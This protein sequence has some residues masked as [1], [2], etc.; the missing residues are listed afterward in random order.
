MKV[1]NLFLLYQLHGGAHWPGSL[2]K[3]LVDGLG[4]RDMVGQATLRLYTQQKDVQ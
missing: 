2:L 3:E 1:C 4:L